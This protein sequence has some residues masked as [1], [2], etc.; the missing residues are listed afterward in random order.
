MI[1]YYIPTFIIAAAASFAL[2][3]LVRRV[4]IKK[5]WLDKGAD[6]EKSI[7]NQYLF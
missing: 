3:P 5:G 1:K 2:T 7:R 4:S 6:I